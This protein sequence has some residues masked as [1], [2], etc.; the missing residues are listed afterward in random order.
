MFSASVLALNVIQW[1]QPT[2]GSTWHSQQQL[3]LCWTWN[4]PKH[5]ELSHHKSL[6][7]MTPHTYVTWQK[8]ILASLTLLFP[9]WKFSFCLRFSSQ[10]PSCY[11]IPASRSSCSSFLAYGG[12]NIHDNKCFLYAVYALQVISSFSIFPQNAVFVLILFLLLQ[13]TDSFISFLF[14]C[15][16]FIFLVFQEGWSLVILVALNFTMLCKF[17]FLKMW[18]YWKNMTCKIPMNL[19]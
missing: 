8:Y 14:I 16:L 17:D 18:S 11:N 4:M 15:L 12:M 3:L 6:Y 13:K 9:Q 5:N 1:Y 19:L 10:N 7:W 2:W